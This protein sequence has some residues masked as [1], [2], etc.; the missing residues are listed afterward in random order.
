MYQQLRGGVGKEVYYRA[1]RRDARWLSVAEGPSV[2]IDG[3]NVALRNMSLGG[4]LVDAPATATTIESDRDLEVEVRFHDELVLAATARIVREEQKP[5]IRRLGLRVTGD[6]A[7]PE[8]LRRRMRD[9]AVRRSV[10]AGCSVF[11]ATPSAY[12]GAVLEAALVMQ[13][14]RKLLGD[15]ERELR[16]DSTAEAIE[17]LARLEALAEGRIREDWQRVRARAALESDA[18]G[19]ERP[20]QLNAAKRLTETVLTPLLVDGLVWR[21]AYQKPRGYPG[22]FELMNIMYEKTR[23][24]ETIYGRLTHVL[25]C[26]ERLAST[27]EARRDYLTAFLASHLRSGEVESRQAVRIA[28]LGSGPARELSELM[29]IRPRAQRLVVTL[30]DQD[31]AALDYAQRALLEA[32]KGWPGSLE[33]RLRHIAFADL[34]R[35]DQ[36][37]AELG[38][39]DLFYSAGFFDYLPQSIAASLLE[40]MWRLVGKRGCLLVGNAAEL[41]EAAWVPEF[42]LDWHMTYRNEG[43]LRQLCDGIRDA[44]TLR[45]ESDRTETWHFL[46]LQ[47]P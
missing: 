28:N 21:H 16:E 26:E 42:V 2:I 10:Q 8:D 6:G 9:A 7:N 31:A 17:N 32:S 46:S 24:G 13:H 18:I 37:L 33:L 20:E 36:L 29:K 34:L 11:E 47:R 27:L 14:W 25:G 40:Q 19:V 38:N 43:H 3:H 15:R 45:I 35:N 41:D 23:V 12:R 1:P 22:D 39:Q 4:M 30:I 44:S 5:R